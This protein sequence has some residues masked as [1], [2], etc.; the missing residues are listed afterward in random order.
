M[1]PLCIILL[2]SVKRHLVWIRREIAQIKHRLQAKTLL[3]NYA[4]GFWCGRTTKDGLFHWRKCYYELWTHAL[5]RSNGFNKKKNI[6]MVYF[7]TNMK[8]VASQ[9]INWWTGVVWII[10]MFGLSFWRHPFTAED[11]LVDKW[12]NATFLQMRWRNKLIYI[13]DGLRGSKCSENFHFWVNYF[14]NANESEHLCYLSAV[15]YGFCTNRRQD[16]QSST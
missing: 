10:V 7:V 12:C 8:F 14:F 2:F 4:G 3:N 9:D 11:P 13:L 5:A 15:I 16:I 6:L 1:S